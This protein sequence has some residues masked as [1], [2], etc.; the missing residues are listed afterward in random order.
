MQKIEDQIERRQ[1]K[2]ERLN[3]GAHK[4]SIKNSMIGKDA[5]RNE[6]WHYKEEPA[7]VFVKKFEVVEKKEQV[8]Q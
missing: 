2:I 8:Q 7:K 5:D 1:N 3:E 6:Y 4:T